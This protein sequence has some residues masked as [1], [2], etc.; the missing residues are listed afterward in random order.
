MTVF[1]LMIALDMRSL[2]LEFTR[3][4][5]R[6]LY[7]HQM[8]AEP[9]SFTPSRNISGIAYDADLQQLTI[10]FRSGW[11]YRYDEVP[12]DAADG[13]SQALSANDYLRLFIE[14]QFQYQR[15]N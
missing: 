6:R 4:A 3:A 12:Q 9:I 15:I 13:F 10:Q 7:N 11:V 1:C 5:T 2:L 8:A 14:N